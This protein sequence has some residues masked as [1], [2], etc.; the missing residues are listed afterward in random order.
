MVKN[1]HIYTFNNDLK[2]I[3]QKQNEIF[4]PVVKASTDY[5]LNEIDKPPKFRMINNADE[6][7]KLEFDK[8]EKK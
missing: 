6:I 3:Q 5:Y 7:L 1:N 4:N 8:D 2:S